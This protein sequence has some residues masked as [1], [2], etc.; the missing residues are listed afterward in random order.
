[1]TIR[2]KKG[3]D[4]EKKGLCISQLDE[5]SGFSVR[6]K[7]ICTEDTFKK[8]MYIVELVDH[9]I[10][11][12]EHFLDAVHIA[13]D[14]ILDNSTFIAIKDFNP[15][16]SEMEKCVDVP[17]RDCEDC[18]KRFDDDIRVLY[19]PVISDIGFKSFFAEIKLS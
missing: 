15:S 8:F 3:A 16:G 19:N 9:N 7:F 2:D 13:M 11:E 1:M 14:N 5:I 4:L 18:E 6:E 10:W 12:L 17:W